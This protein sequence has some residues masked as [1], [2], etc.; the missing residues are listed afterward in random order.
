MPGGGSGDEEFL[1]ESVLGKRPQRD[2]MCQRNEMDRA[3][4]GAFQTFFHGLSKGLECQG[5]VKAD[6]LFG[7]K[8]LHMPLL[9]VK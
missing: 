6:T 7:M 1:P 5:T 8:E 4:P 3:D 2:E 9:S